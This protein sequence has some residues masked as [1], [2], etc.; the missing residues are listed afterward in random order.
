M[1]AHSHGTAN[2][3]GSFLRTGTSSQ[4]NA[5]WVGTGASFGY[6]TTTGNAAAVGASQSH[7][8]LQPSRAVLWCIRF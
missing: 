2:G 7:N 5:N 6:D 1:P 3:T 4:G 8:N